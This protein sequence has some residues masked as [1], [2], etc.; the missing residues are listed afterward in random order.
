[1]F[2]FCF[3]CSVVFT[4]WR[5]FYEVAYCEVTWTHL[6]YLNVNLL[7]GGFT[8][9][10]W[11]QVSSQY[12]S[13]S[14]K[15]SLFWIVNLALPSVRNMG[16]NDT[17]F[18]HKQNSSYLKVSSQ[19]RTLSVFVFCSPV[20]LSSLLSETSSGQSFFLLFCFKQLLNFVTWAVVEYM[21]LD[22]CQMNRIFYFLG[23]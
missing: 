17:G 9:N 22:F 4:N 21:S 14:K 10:G 13:N 16:S 12:I 23:V 18:S 3:K 11:I 5:S 19:I 2:L 20:F 8:L 6:V 15:L 7:S 1:M